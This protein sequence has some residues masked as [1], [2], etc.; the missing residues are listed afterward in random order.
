MSSNPPANFKSSQNI[1]GGAQVNPFK[2]K[3]VL[4]TGGTGSLGKA[5]LKKLTD[6]EVRKIIVFSRDELKQSMLQQQYPDLGG[7]SPYRYFIGDV[8]DKERLVR[9]FN[10]VDIVIHAAALKQ[11]GACEY[12]CTEAM[13]TNVLGSMNVVEAAIDAG[14]AK[15][16]LISTDKSS[17][18][19]NFYGTTKKLAEGLF[20]QGNSYS[21]GTGTKF[22]VCRYGNVLG[23]RGSVVPIFIEQGKIGEITITDK[24]MTR[25][26]I[27][28]KRAVE[29][30]IDSIGKM[31]GGEIF[32]PKIPS[33]RIVD[34]AYAIAPEA[35]LTEIG[36]RPGEKINEILLNE[37]E[38]R[39]ATDCGNHYIIYP[40]HHWWT[41]NEQRNGVPLPDGYQYA[42]DCN[43][44]W[45]SQEQLRQIVSNP[46]YA[47]VV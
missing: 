13:K 28:M 21:G 40:V 3:S 44:E 15:V 17:Y 33:M 24:R 46:H 41:L 26:W 12:N 1:S 47:E 19:I 20:V 7:S 16:L 30:V 11:I 23:S 25:F 32:I 27:T 4:I 39:S 34:L 35:R 37:D 38:A 9:A 8:R 14:V 18:P 42:S 2:D 10:N 29:L 36:I 43:T 5:L 31:L 6:M 22:G 45:L